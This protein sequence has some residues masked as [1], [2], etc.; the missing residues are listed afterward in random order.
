MSTLKKYL[1]AA[2]VAAIVLFAYNKFPIVKR[3][4]GG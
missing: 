4:L 2:A 3:T 1:P